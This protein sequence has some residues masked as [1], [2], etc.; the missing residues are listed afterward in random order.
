V[1]TACY[2]PAATPGTPCD[3]ATNH[4]PTGQ[5]CVLRAGEYICSTTEGEGTDA[6]GD[7]AAGDVPDACSAIGHDEDL[8]QVDDACDRCPHVGDPPQADADNDGVG[9]ACDPRP[10]VADRIARFDAFASIPSDW[11]LPAGW[12]IASDALVGTSVNTSV[13]SLD[14][15]VGADVIAFSHV[16]VTGTAIDTNA[17]MLVNFVS[18]SEFYKCG[19]HVEPRLELVEFPAI[20]LDSQALPSSAWLDADLEVESN[21]GALRCRAARDGSAVE[22]SGNDTSSQGARVGVRIREGTARFE[23][24]V[25]IVRQ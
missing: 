10:G 12:S 6:N 11:T 25:V 14:L 20:A 13:A 3:P 18:S 8:D 19:L 17:G 7:D 15:A 22:I 4:C 16:T 2:S 23:Y 24:L 9:D 1:I 5:M 21:S